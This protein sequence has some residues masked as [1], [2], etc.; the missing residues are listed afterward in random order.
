MKR[1]WATMFE[2]P[3]L[4]RSGVFVCFGEQI[5]DVFFAPFLEEEFADWIDHGLFIRVFTGSHCGVRMRI[6]T[7]EKYTGY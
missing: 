4:G 6:P 5:S 7:E 3:L 1:S 2:L